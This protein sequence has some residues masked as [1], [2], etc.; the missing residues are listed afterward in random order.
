MVFAI[1]FLHICN[2][3][4]TARLMKEL[5]NNYQID[6][7]N[8]FIRDGN[9][10]ALSKVYFHNYDLLFTYGLKCTDDK[11]M[12]EDA[13]QDVFINL[14]K[15]RK[16]IGD[17]KNLVGYLIITFRRKLFLDLNK[18]KR[19]L[20]TDQLPEEQFEFFK[21]TDLD[22]SENENLERI[23][24]IIKQC[25]GN[26]S[27]KQQEIIFLRF[28]NGISYEEIAKILQISVDSCY[29]SVYRS[30]KA[31]RNDVEKILGKGGNIILLVLAK[32]AK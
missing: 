28:E 13:I 23:H 5:K 26:L 9:L 20:L 12:V 15:S 16:S 10:D 7:W 32:L 8:Q 25:I 29:K 30:I 18:Q 24:L 2:L 1:K 4:V 17:V 3:L 22:F 21:G 19:I 27:S 11:R 31:I 6:D 14:I